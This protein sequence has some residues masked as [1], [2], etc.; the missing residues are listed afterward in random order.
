MAANPTLSNRPIISSEVSEWVSVPA[1]WRIKQAVFIGLTALLAIYYAL[2]GYR[3]PAT[4]S[5][6]AD[7][8]SPFDFAGFILFGVLIWLTTPAAWT[9]AVTTFQEAIRR[10]WVTVLLGFAIVMLGVSTLFS[11]MATGEVQKFLRDYGLGFTL[12]LT[13][14]TA[15]FLGTALIPPEIERRTIF[16]IL[17]KPVTRLEFLI[18]K[19]LGLL[20][21]LAMNL[22]FMIIVFLFAYSVFVITREQGLANALAADGSG[23]SRMG[24]FFDVWNLGKALMLDFGTLSI[25]AAFAIM[26]SQFTTGITSTILCFV[27]YFLGQ[28]APYWE[29]LTSGTGDLSNTAKP[30]L[31]PGLT[32]VINFVYFFLPRLDRFDVRER[33]INDAPIAANYIIKASSSGVVYAAVLLAVAYF[34]FSD[35]EF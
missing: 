26:L 24:L 17:S 4:E 6:S 8:L 18:G 20:F 9:V 12:I 30:S 34:A 25:M 23:V 31:G 35:R 7:N 16:T 28:S 22:V 19:Y 27:V 3:S 14:I 21:V 1:S 33:V 10:R 32:A 2:G 29:R 11:F 13:L 15:I 5:G